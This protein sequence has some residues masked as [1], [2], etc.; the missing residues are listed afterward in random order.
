MVFSFC[1]SLGFSTPSLA[2][3]DKEVRDMRR[4]IQELVAKNKE[5]SDRLSA[6][7]TSGAS[8]P[9]A[10]P[11]SGRA[12][13]DPPAGKPARPVKPLA[14]ASAP[15]PSPPALAAAPAPP[16][17]AATEPAADR[18]GLEQRVK[19]LERSRVAQESAV[20]TIIQDSFSKTGSKINEFVTL[21]GALEVMGGRSS[22]FTG[23][24]FDRISLNTAELD[25]EIR[26]NDWMLGTLVLNYNDGSSVLFPTNQG[27]NLGVDRITVD[28]ATVYVGDLQR[29]PLYMKVG[30]D[31]LP[32]GT[33]TGV[34]RSDVLSL[35]NPLTVEI[36]ETRANTVGIGFA[37]PTP[38]PAPPSPPFVAPAVNPLLINP[39]LSAA[40]N[41]IGHT[42]PPARRKAPVPLAGPVEPPPFY[43]SVYVYDANT[44]E[45]VN[46]RFSG[47]LNGR[48]G[49]QARGTCGKSY[50]ELT[51][52]YLCPWALDVSFDY[53]GSVFDSKFLQDGYRT[54]IPRIGK[55]PGIA[56]SMK[57]S[58]GPFLL[59]GEWNSAIK[60]ARFTDDAS[61]RVSITPSAW[62]IALAY[63]F[64]WNPWL[65]TIG[66]RGDYIAVG[67]SRSRDLAG[68]MQATGGTPA[69]VRVGSA[70]ESRL[71]F[72]A[73]EWV[74]NGARLV[75][76]YSHVWDYPRSKGGTGRQSDGVFT[77]L[78][79]VW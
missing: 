61:H 40:A 30:R 46:R 72:T 75:I 27:T 11:A 24:K 14:R 79:F 12:S 37:L 65:E 10:E 52:S 16:V 41:Y 33:S 21:G 73:G 29:F 26:V 32:F 64:D 63:Q 1:L 69:T 2:V 51:E 15:P 35:E 76:E 31:V 34:H 36:F 3:D 60:P 49:Y 68:V 45:G 54:F 9:R 57:F 70:P 25:L 8:T 42:L 7:E 22:D 50:S 53:I 17:P 58:F 39:L 28:R 4:A 56:A 67:Y 13:T 55:A 6:L 18:A 59:V 77:A 48:L 44:V 71:T 74:L 43:G 78:T 23:T 62:Q 20:R 19:D 66:S 38:K 5:L 47:N